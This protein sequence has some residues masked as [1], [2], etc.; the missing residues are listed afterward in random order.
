MRTESSPYFNVAYT[1]WYHGGN[2]PTA[3]PAKPKSKAVP[4]AP[5][6][7]KPKPAAPQPADTQPEPDDD[8]GVGG[9]PAAPKAASAAPGSLAALLSGIPD[10]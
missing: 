10:A 4:K 8:D 2:A 7:P 1:N 9:E 5:S 6:I 3:P